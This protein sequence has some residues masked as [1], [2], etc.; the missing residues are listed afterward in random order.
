MARAVNLTGV[1]SERS[2]DTR[3]GD[4]SNALWGE[5]HGLTALE[6]GDLDNE[7]RRNWASPR[8]HAVRWSATT[9]SPS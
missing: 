4:L 2:H 6:G 7:G 8:K 5:F 9:R 1:R 3:I